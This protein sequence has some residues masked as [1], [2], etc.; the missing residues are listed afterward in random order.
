MTVVGKYSFANG[1]EVVSNDF[2][3]Q[4]KEIYHCIEEIDVSKFKTKVSKEK[5]M[6]GEML[7][8]IVSYYYHQ[9]PM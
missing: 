7:Y 8:L 5:T 3:A 9:N 6:M 1:E 4:L 2:S